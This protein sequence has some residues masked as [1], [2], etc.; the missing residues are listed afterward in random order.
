MLQRNLKQGMAVSAS[1]K[2]PCVARSK[3]LVKPGKKELTRLL[4]SACVDSNGIE[5][6]SLPTLVSRPSNEKNEKWQKL[7]A[8]SICPCVA[9]ARGM[10][11][12]NDATLSLW[13][14]AVSDVIASA[15]DTCINEPECPPP[16]LR[17]IEAE[18]VV[19]TDAKLYLART[20]CVC[21]DQASKPSQVAA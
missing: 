21:A 5:L 9:Q 3:R 8:R 15:D 4:G 14:T 12:K 20:R 19:S 18:W 16:P 11:A 6:V 17:E 2:C 10:K 1:P 7:M 13:M